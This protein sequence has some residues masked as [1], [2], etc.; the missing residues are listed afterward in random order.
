MYVNGCD[1]FLFKKTL[2]YFTLDITVTIRIEMLF[3]SYYYYSS[4]IFST[5]LEFF[6]FFN[7]I[8]VR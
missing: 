6:I 3:V 4:K 1:I 8:L 2:H 7:T 5:E